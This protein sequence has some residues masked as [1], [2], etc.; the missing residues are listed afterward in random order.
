M[1]FYVYVLRSEKDKNLY[2]GSTSDLKRRLQ[3]HN[4]GLVESTAARKPFDLVYYEA[5]LSKDKAFK[6]EKYFKT[7]FGRRYLKDRI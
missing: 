7:G 1:F 4:S 3:E 5:G 2:V 6:R